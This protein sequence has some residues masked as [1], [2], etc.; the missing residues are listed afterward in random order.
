MTILL[1]VKFAK[2]AKQN[3]GIFMIPNEHS[4]PRLTGK[5][6]DNGGIKLENKNLHDKIY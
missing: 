4:M 3:G 5:P 1:N 2:Q 6:L